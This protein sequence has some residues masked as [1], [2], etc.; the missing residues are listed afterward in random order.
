TSPP[1]T[2]SCAPGAPR[3]AGSAS[4]RR[5]S[6]GARGCRAARSTGA[7]SR[8]SGSEGQCDDERPLSIARRPKSP[9]ASKS[10]GFPRYASKPP[11]RGLSVVRGVVHHRDGR[12]FEH[13]A[14]S[15]LLGGGGSPG[16]L[17]RLLPAERA[18]SELRPPAE[19]AKRVTEGSLPEQPHPLRHHVRAPA[20]FQIRAR[21]APGRLETARD[22][23][24]EVDQAELRVAWSG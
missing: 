18:G 22:R 11:P 17:R 16:R 15:I 5:R 1:S 8:S 13:A 10:G 23:V 21:L 12:A 3:D 6:R 9:R 20:R 14:P 19:A 7:G 24:R 4:W 2:T